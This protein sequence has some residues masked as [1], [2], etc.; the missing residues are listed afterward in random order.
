MPDEGPFLEM[1]LVTVEGDHF[2]TP[3]PPQIRSI[4]E[5]D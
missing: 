1:G 2:A 3:E 5:S 4:D